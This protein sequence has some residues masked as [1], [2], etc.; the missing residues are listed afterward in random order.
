MF[1]KRRSTVLSVDQLS[2]ALRVSRLLF[3][4]LIGLTLS[5][6]ANQAQHSLLNAGIS[7]GRATAAMELLA[8]TAATQSYTQ[9]ALNEAAEHIQKADTLL[10]RDN[11]S[12]LQPDMYDLDGLAPELEETAARL[13]DRLAEQI[14]SR[15][16]AVQTKLHQI[17]S[18]TYDAS[19]G[20][21]Y[22]PTCDAYFFQVGYYFSRA[23]IASFIGEVSTRDSAHS[24]MNQAVRGGLQAVFEFQC[25]FGS[26]DSWNALPLVS[27]PKFGPY[28]TKV[29][30]LRRIAW[31]SEPPA[32][33][34]APRLRRADSEEDF[35]R[36]QSSLPLPP[37]PIPAPTPIDP[38]GNFTCDQ[39]AR[40]SIEQSRRYYEV[41]CGRETG[42]GWSRDFVHHKDWCKRSRES[43]KNKP[44]SRSDPTPE[45]MIPLREQ[46][47][48]ECSGGY[49]RQPSRCTFKIWGGNQ[50]LLKIGINADAG[51]IYAI[52]HEAWFDHQVRY[53]EGVSHYKTVEREDLPALIQAMC[54]RWKLSRIHEI[55]R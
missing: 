38:E 18:K 23:H 31:Y 1:A 14:L 48:Q 55:R 52:D 5:L 41:N 28:A 6:R 33:P 13:G 15:I 43:E 29:E 35:P 20:L 44:F 26:E 25:G 45:E 36:L 37:L 3:V 4:V 9:G 46:V 47:L 40:K 11:L 22:G 34:H 21:Q 17:L 8:P 10:A 12:S 27:P 32:N 54:K 16:E 2:K 24:S 53:P 51:R 42:L 30:P 39:Y 50:G 19:G 49:D 7:L